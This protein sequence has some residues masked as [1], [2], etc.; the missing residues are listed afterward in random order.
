MGERGKNER[1]KKVKEMGKKK[2]SLGET[3]RVVAVTLASQEPLCYRA[4]LHVLHYE[5]TSQ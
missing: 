1:K 5:D 3:S 2:K 4:E